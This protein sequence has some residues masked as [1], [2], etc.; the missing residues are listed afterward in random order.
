MS[1]YQLK[2]RHKREFPGSLTELRR[3]ILLKL[4]TGRG[5]L[6]LFVF[7]QLLFQVAGALTTVIFLRFLYTEIFSDILPIELKIGHNNQ[8]AE[9]L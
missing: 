7:G 8:L 4:F 5:L 1:N 6:F 9:I 3:W 2:N